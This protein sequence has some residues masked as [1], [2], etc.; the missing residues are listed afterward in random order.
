MP[1]SANL[2][3]LQSCSE[4]NFLVGLV[5]LNCS[6]HGGVNFPLEPSEGL[7]LNKS[8]FRLTVNPAIVGPLSKQFPQQ[9]RQIARYQRLEQSNDEEEMFQ[10]DQR[11]EIYLI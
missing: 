11:R 8:N 9:F 7:Q 2:F 5:S 1:Q 6:L 4:A 3:V 10:I